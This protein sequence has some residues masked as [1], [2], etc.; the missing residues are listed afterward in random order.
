MNTIPPTLL[1][2]L[3]ETVPE[4]KFQTDEDGDRPLGEIGVDS[5]DKMALLLAVQEQYDLEFTEAEIK[6]LRTLRD[7]AEKIPA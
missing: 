6:D 2:L 7:I 5:L 1:I 3:Q 4:A